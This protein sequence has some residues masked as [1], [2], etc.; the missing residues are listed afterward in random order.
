[1]MYDQGTRKFKFKAIGT[2][3]FILNYCYTRLEAVQLSYTSPLKRANQ[4]E[5]A[6]YVLGWIVATSS[7]L[8]DTFF[9]TAGSRQASAPHG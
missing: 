2:I 9:G 7:V 1:M 6:R 4:G 8:S 5:I 3:L